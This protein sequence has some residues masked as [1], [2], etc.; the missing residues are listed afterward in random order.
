MTDKEKKAVSMK[1]FVLS[2]TKPQKFISKLR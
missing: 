2:A 1:T